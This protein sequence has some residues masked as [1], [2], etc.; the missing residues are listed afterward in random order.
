MAKS[1]A[2]KG[3]PK[4]MY[5]QKAVMTLSKKKQYENQMKGY[6]NQL[7]TIDK[8]NF[9]AESIKSQGEMVIY[10]IKLRCKQWSML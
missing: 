4:Q 10:L 9:T 5:K 3:S 1:Q 2:S 7:M 8:V 6:M